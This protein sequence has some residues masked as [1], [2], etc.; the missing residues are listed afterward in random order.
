MH[1][2]FH[3]GSMILRSN[4]AMRSLSKNWHWLAGQKP[5]AGIGAWSSNTPQSCRAASCP[6]AAWPAERVT[7]PIGSATVQA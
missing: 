6:R 4:K 7:Q 1:P 3:D 2:L 5:V